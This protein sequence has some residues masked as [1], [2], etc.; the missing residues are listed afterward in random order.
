MCMVEAN[1]AEKLLSMKQANL[2]LNLTT[3]RTRERE[4]L[5]EMERQS[6][7]LNRHPLYAHEG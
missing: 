6:T 5:D 4:F 2:G 3:K 7:E 1:V